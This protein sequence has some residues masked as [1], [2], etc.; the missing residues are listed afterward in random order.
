MTE[1]TVHDKPE[2]PPEDETTQSSKENEAGSGSSGPSAMRRLAEEAEAYAQAKLGRMMSGLGSKVGG[3]TGKLGEVAEGKINP[4]GLV[5]KVAKET[6]KQPGSV[7]SL[8]KAGTKGLAE[9][10]KS[11][12]KGGK[13]GQ[14]GGKSMNIVEDINIGMP[15]DIV[16]NH[17]T[18]FEKFPQ[19]SK[20]V[21]SV[22]RE[23]EVTT[24][25]KA[26]IAF[27]NRNWKSKILDMAPDERIVWKSEGQT[28][29]N[30]IVTFHPITEDLTKMLMVL[31]YIPHG[32]VEKVA[33]L[34]RAQGRRARLDL[35]LFRRY[36]MMHAEPTEGWRGEIRDGEVVRSPEEV[37]GEESDDKGK[38]E[39]S[40]DK[41]NIEQ[42]REKD[43]NDKK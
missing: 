10:A 30:G 17:W 22:D 4:S 43:K 19:W 34:W 20:G 42:S 36:V 2:S 26:K 15:V 40:G 9:R 35:K 16:Y 21:Q 12:L 33:N 14:P 41:S 11:A 8:A 13:S 5:G 7:A 29:V 18:E 39:E 37:E 28:I 24:N 1:S 31:E 27:S 38:S 23:D 25:W 3:L 32:F 6:L